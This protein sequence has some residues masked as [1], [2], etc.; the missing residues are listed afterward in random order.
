MTQ[1]LARFSARRPWLAIAVWIVAIVLGFGLVATLLGNALTGEPRVT[2]ATESEQGYDLLAERFPTDEAEET[3]EIVVV[4]SDS[5]SAD[6]RA[7]RTRVARLGADLLGAGATN[8]ATRAGAQELVSS[9]GDAVALLVA[10]GES[11]EDTVEAVVAEVERL[12][13]ERDFEAGITGD[14]TSDSDFT[15]LSLDDLKEGELFFGGP[16]A[17]VILLLVFGT[18]VAGLVPLI[19]ALVSILLALALVGLLGIPF[20]FSVFVQNMIFGMGLALGI[21][22]AL[23]ILSRYREERTEGR[24]KLEAIAAAGSTASRAVL[25]SGMAFVLAMLG[26]LLVPNTIMRSLA[27]GA[28]LVGVVS[29]LAALTLLPAVLGL[30]GDR[31]NALRIPLFG[32]AAG[33]EAGRESRL[34]GGVVRAV[35]RRPLLSLVVAAG[36]LVAAAVPVLQLETG[37]A[38]ISTI[39]DRLPSKQGFLLLNEEFPGQTVDPVQIVVDGDAGSADVRQGIE[40]LEAV[41]ARAD[42][43]G[44]PTREVNEAGNTT[45]VTVPVAGDP[46]SEQAVAAVRDLRGEV[47]PRAFAGAPAQAYVTGM[48]AE[49][50]DYYDVMDRWLPRVFVFVLGLSFILLT[51][52]FRSVVLAAKAIVLNLLAV[53]AAYGLLVLVFVKGYGNEIFGFQ[54]VDAVEAWVPLF[55]FAVLF[56]LSMDYQVF[57]LSRIRERFLSTGDNDGAVAFGVGSTARLITGAALIIIAVFA[58]F[59]RGDL[60]MFQQMGFGV[61]VA[62]F[63]DA[64]IIRSV[65]VPASM[66]LLG[67][68]NWYLPSWLRW[69]P[70]F[71]VEGK[72]PETRRPAAAPATR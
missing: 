64:T 10:L 12:D 37:Q 5:L 32:R 15:Q 50:I 68:W 47:V 52:A 28:I 44:E 1:R 42:L 63:I 25:F 61:A 65:L 23:F 6:D 60:V 18:L 67:R 4:R 72:E 38:G 48:T 66:K 54:Q 39:P 70:E 34:W 56:G 58:G 20:E 9:D 30:L 41:L 43:F 40:R 8:V 7:F 26:L 49:N 45:V 16:A 14:W 21:D 33:R 71:H 2:S 69:L 17:L 24:D 35:M 53:G 36:L 46:V 59:A 51:I 57:L 3:T 31:V 27:A 62:L 29:V 22:Y 55:L 13:A 11:P 19:L